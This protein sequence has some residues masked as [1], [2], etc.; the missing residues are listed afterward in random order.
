M[1]GV[2]VRITTANAAYGQHATIPDFLHQEVS[3]LTCLIFF[4]HVNLIDVTSQVAPP[5]TPDLGLIF[6][7]WFFGNQLWHLCLR[8]EEKL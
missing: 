4:I 2:F 5:S 8:E 3:V 6:V 1:C 7:C